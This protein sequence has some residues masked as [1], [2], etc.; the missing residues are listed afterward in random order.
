MAVTSDD[1]MR[2]A[3]AALLFAKLQQFG[4]KSELHVWQEGGH[5]YG[6]YKRGKACDGWEDDLKVWLKLNGML[7]E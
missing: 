4:V 1:K 7:P 3:Q 6:L 5:G 2:G